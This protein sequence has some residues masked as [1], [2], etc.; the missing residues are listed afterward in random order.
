M[1]EVAPQAAVMKWLEDSFELRCPVCQ[2]DRLYRW[3]RQAGLQRFRCYT[4]KHT[5]TA[6]SG[7]PLT[8]LR[9]KEQWLNYSAALIEGLTARASAKRC[10]IDKNTSFRWR[11]RF[12]ALPATTKANHLQ[13][14]VEADETFFSS[15][16][17]GQHHL[18]RPPRKHGKQI[19]ARGTGKDQVPVLVVRDRSGATANF[20][21]TAIDK[22]TIDPPLQAILAK[23][24]IFCS[25]GC[26][27]PICN[28]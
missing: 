7:T 15:S 1:S 22:K 5:F 13:G 23:D 20:M 11:Y 14:I 27:L 28:S 16:R 21:L 9:H 12:L 25:D 26:R 4:C 3:G 17:K 18:N 8:R 2:A 24:A 19:H 6:V 10:G